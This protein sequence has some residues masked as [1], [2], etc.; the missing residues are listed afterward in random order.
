MSLTVWAPVTNWRGT[1]FCMIVF[2]SDAVGEDDAL[3]EIALATGSR[4]TR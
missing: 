3:T 1:G 4:E 2:G